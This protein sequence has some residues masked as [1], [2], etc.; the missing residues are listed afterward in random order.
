MNSI[1]RTGATISGFVAI[2]TVAG[3][4]AAR[5][6]VS[7]AG[8]AAVASQPPAAAT[9]APTD[10]PTPSLDPQT[11]YVR[12]AA[13]P[14]IVTVTQTNPPVVQGKPK[15]PPVFHVIVPVS[16]AGDDGGG[17]D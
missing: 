7:P 17:D 9:A 16:G 2:L 13:T 6:F 8:V 14:E 12:P 1:H 15:P 11:I 10:A 3:A 5:S 4:L